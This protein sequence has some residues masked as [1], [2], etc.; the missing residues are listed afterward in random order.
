[1]RAGAAVLLA[2]V[3]A[4]VAVP[5]GRPD[6]AGCGLPATSPLWV[7]YA[8]HDAPITP[9]PG[10]VLAVSSGTTVPEQMR[11]AGAATIFFD[12]HLNDRVGTPSAP[13]DP[14]TIKSKAAKEFAFAQQV[15]GCATPLIA[16]NELFGAQTPTPWSAT[17][18]QYRA[19]VLSLVQALDALG[20]T[21]GITI[22]NPPYTGGDAAEWWRQAAQAAILIRQVYFTAPGPKGLYAMGPVLASRAMRRGMRG[23]V[24]HF[25]QIGIPA[26]RVALELQFQSAP[27]QGG[28]QGLEPKNAWL[29]I[30]K[31]EALAARQVAAETHIEGIWS[32]GWPA[33]SAAGADPDKPA[34]ACVYLWT[35]DQSLCDGPALAGPGFDTSLT[36]GQIILP[37]G[38]RCSLGTQT[39]RKADVGRAAALTGDLDSAASAML[40]RAV[41]RAAEPIDPATVLSA[42]RA[43]VRDRFGG[44]VPAY[45]AALLAA[46]VTLAD[47]RAIIADR[48]GRERVEERFQPR[49]PSAA[50]IAA[51]L[52]TYA[53][54]LVRLVQVSPRAPWLGDLDR[55]L[56]VETLAPIQVFRLGTN[57]TATLDTIDGRFVV[58]TLAAPLP[59]LALPRAQAVGVAK[60]VLDR[61]AR[62]D[63]FQSWL[64]G[65]ENTL[66]ASAVCA[67]D[68]VPTEADVDL[69][70]W[71]P[72]LGE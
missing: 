40:E 2:W 68:Q 9:R 23:L 8:G 5:S 47:A 31:L 43:I 61:F 7:D 58:R 50:N 4:C 64:Q 18:A 70:V 35:R 51:F 13:A 46:H 36:E 17:N 55:G 11:Q 45:R 25:A 48:L 72:F 19:N 59:V 15:T 54:T 42:E 12:L 10:M 62:D 32:W 39:I 66:L 33:F 53:G 28:R 65:R 27:G 22:A 52:S 37:A 1:M 3:L 16:E 21:V 57:R 69:S 26:S 6:A 49:P 24:A 41:L 60:S 38:V 63:V 67:R 34:A 20:A 30:V 29:E 71:V 44:S 56:A 14:S